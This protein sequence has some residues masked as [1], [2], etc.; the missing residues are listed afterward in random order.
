MKP[1]SKHRREGK[2]TFENHRVINVS[3]ERR[4]WEP[5]SHDGKVT[6]RAL[7]V[8]DRVAKGNSLQV[9]GNSLQVAYM[10]SH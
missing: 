7:T 10:Y 4:A 1:G 9:I 5:G 8:V 2:S 3:R 6:G